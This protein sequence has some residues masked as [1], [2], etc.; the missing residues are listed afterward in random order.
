[1]KR[2]LLVIIPS[3]ILL[4]AAAAQA[5]MRQ[6]AIGPKV[7]IY[8]NNSLFMLGVIGEIPM[9]PNLD[10]EP[11]LETIFGIDHTTRLVLDANGRFSFDL[12]GSDVRPFL[13]GGLGLAFDF[14]NTG[15]AS[16]SRTDFRLNLG[17]GAVFNSRSLI[18]Y[19]GGLKIYLLSK[20]NSDVLLQAGANF[21]L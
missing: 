4:C 14:V 11:G 12:Q 9:T 16:S 15:L 7:G 6:N 20:D 13:L 18:Q 19:W 17:G 5:Q 10:F 2:S 3:L 1:M 8:F 21:Y